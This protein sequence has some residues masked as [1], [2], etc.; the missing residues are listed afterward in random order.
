MPQGGRLGENHGGNT[1]LKPEFLSLG[2]KKSQHFLGT[3]NP[4]RFRSF[5]LT[6]HFLIRCQPAK[7]FFPGEFGNACSV[8][9]SYG[10]YVA[11]T[12]SVQPVKRPIGKL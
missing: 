3:K 1:W 7:A 5:F 11:F 4:Q 9:S 6:H 8:A 10:F 12:E 2:W